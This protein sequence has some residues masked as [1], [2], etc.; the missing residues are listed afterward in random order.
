VLTTLP[1]WSEMHTQVGYRASLWFRSADYPEYEAVAVNYPEWRQP[2]AF[3]PDWCEPAP[4]GPLL[5]AH[6][7]LTR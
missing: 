1:R 4:S 7:R 3:F 5:R 2:G 6:V